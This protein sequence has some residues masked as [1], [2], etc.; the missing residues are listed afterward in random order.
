MQHVFSTS[1]L[2]FWFDSRGLGSFLGDG[3]GP[4]FRRLCEVN[5]AVGLYNPVLWIAREL[6]VSIL[7][8]FML[9]TYHELP[10]P[11]SDTPSRWVSRFLGAY[12]G[13]PHGVFFGIDA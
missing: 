11:R 1:S 13:S 3:Q 12:E 10:K 5:R 8:I 2:G 4:G 6:E 9:I 7:M